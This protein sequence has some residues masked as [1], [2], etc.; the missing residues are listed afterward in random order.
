MPFE[1][2]T[3]LNMDPQER[4]HD[5]DTPVFQPRHADSLPLI[6]GFA[7]GKRGDL[8]YWAFEREEL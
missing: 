2:E 3:R 1:V 6:V 4:C 7:G 8:S 5:T